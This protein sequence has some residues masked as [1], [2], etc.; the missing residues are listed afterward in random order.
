MRVAVGGLRGRGRAAGGCCGGQP[1][2]GRVGT[3]EGGC[4]GGSG[5]DTS[6][7]GAAG[8]CACVTA[9][10]EVD[11]G[12]CAGGSGAAD[13]S[14]SS[15]ASDSSTEMPKSVARPSRPFE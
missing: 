13:A 9:S 12:V 2:A 6:G 10:G 1:Y 5:R 14:G 15:A 3:P 11:A 7:T 8:T 4:S